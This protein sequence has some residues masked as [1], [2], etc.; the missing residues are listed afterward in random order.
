[1]SKVLAEIENEIIKCMKCGNCQAVCPLYKE[2][3]AEAAV[4]RGKVRLAEAALKGQVEYTSG[5]AHRFDLC[6]TCMACVANCP[7]GVRVDEIVLAARAALTENRGLPLPKRAAIKTL[8]R[9]KLMDM[10]VKA[11]SMA[12]GLLFRRVDR[13]MSPRFPIG[14][15]L[16]RVL[17]PPAP[18]SLKAL[19]AERNSVPGPVM[20]VAFFAGCVTNYVF[21]EVG[22][23][24][25]EVLQKHGIEIVFPHAQHCCGTPVLIHGARDTAEE[26]AA[27]QVDIFTEAGADAIVT[28]CGTCGEAFRYHYPRLLAGRPAYARRAAALAECT[29]DIAEFLT[30]VVP[31]NE[32]LLGPVDVSFTYH[33]PCHI[34]RG[35]R[36]AGKPE[37]L[38]K[39]IPQAKYIPLKEPGRCCGGAG[40]FSLLHYELSSGVLKHK[41]ADIASTGAEAVVTGCGSCRIQLNEGLAREGMPQRVL[42]TVEMLAHSMRN[43]RERRVGYGN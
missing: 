43:A 39:A 22:L 27:S 29:Y 16:R 1:M 3:R 6:L 26:M 34:G 38:L 24:L 9:P 40:S 17:P 25:L 33:E 41:L 32:D 31:L 2:T 35:L 11:A 36:A 5:L 4:A 20:R 12:R 15:E 21:P 7:C 30:G 14:L 23:A 19:L 37:K 8:S 18:K 10:G 13:G 28:V 42:H